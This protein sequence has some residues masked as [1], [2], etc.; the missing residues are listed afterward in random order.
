[1]ALRMRCALFA[2]D[3]VDVS[4]QNLNVTKLRTSILTAALR[5]QMMI[6]LNGPEW[7]DAEKLHNVIFRALRVW[8]IGR[9]M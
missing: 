4:V 2:F 5:D 3:I 8:C 6:V 7:S 9:H 1:M